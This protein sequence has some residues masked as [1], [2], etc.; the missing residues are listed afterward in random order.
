MPAQLLGYRGR[1]FHRLGVDF[2]G[3]SQFRGEEK[4]LGAGVDSQH[5]EH[6]LAIARLLKQLQRLPAH[7]Y[8]LRFGHG[9]SS[10]QCDVALQCPE[11]ILV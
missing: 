3:F 7:F 5:I 9:K 8:P 11:A 1:S 10:S 4:R 2:A 6:Q